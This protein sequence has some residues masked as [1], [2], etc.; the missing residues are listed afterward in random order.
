MLARNVSVTFPEASTLISGTS[1]FPL[2]L[3]FACTR[4]RRLALS[5]CVD[6]G[7]TIVVPAA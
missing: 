4:I 1:T 3:S 6:W 7:I 2:A 5:P